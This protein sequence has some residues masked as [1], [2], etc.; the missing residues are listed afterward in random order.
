[1]DGAERATIASGQG[2]TNTWLIMAVALVSGNVIVTPSGTNGLHWHTGYECR[3]S[4]V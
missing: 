1:L 2:T 4:Y 3:D